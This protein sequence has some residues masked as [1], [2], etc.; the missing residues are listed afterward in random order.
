M[1]DKSKPKSVEEAMYASIDEDVG[2]WPSYKMLAD[3]YLDQDNFFMAD[4]I[5]WLINNKL[6]PYFDKDD[7][8]YS[9]FRMCTHST[10]EPWSRGYNSNGLLQPWFI[11][12]EVWDLL[13]DHRR[14]CR[15]GY[16]EYTTSQL[17][18]SAFCTAWHEAKLKGWDGSNAWDGKFAT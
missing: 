5:L 2:Y 11:A 7:K 10:G 13:V 12:G 14:K 16:K 8:D 17:A 6:R 18:V 1:L 3:W 4:P 15:G 9:W